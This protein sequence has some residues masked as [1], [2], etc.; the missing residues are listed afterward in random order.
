MQN[1]YPNFLGSTEEKISDSFPKIKIKL[2][3]SDKI[4][5]LFTAKASLNR[6]LFLT[7]NDSENKYLNMLLRKLMIIINNSQR[8]SD[9]A[10]NSIIIQSFNLLIIRYLSIN[11]FSE[12]FELVI[13]MGSFPEFLADVNNTKIYLLKALIEISNDPKVLSKGLSLIIQHPIKNTPLANPII[14]KAIDK[15]YSIPE[16]K[17]CCRN[18][19]DK[20]GYEFKQT[21]IAKL[22]LNV[23]SCPVFFNDNK[24]AKAWGSKIS[25]D[26]LGFSNALQ[27][28]ALI[29]LSR[30][31]EYEGHIENMCIYITQ[32]QRLYPN[33][34]EVA[35]WVGRAFLYNLKYEKT[36][37]YKD[38]SSPRNIRLTQY[39]SLLINPS[40]N[41]IDKLISVF[42]DITIEFS[43]KQLLKLVLKSILEP[44]LNKSAEE[45]RT[46]AKYSAIIREFDNNC[47]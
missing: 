14:F 37:S 6:C 41:T 26:G 3:L 15:I 21:E 40:F 20:A 39:F 8:R 28:D 33:D 17:E 43:E 38:T 45:I 12:A 44:K 30:V 22:I 5:F 36:S 13:K 32:A 11:K 1:Y 24:I 7:Y 23:C 4:L 10:L 27:R 42:Q 16:G 47:G 9:K 18:V 19:I 2:S 29:I 35:Y 34:S 46:I 25:T 31:A